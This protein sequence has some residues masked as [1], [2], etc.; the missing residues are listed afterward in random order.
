MRLRFVGTNG[1]E[2][3]DSMGCFGNFMSGVEHYRDFIGG[4]Y[5]RVDVSLSAIT[6]KGFSHKDVEK[7]IEDLKASSDLYKNVVPLVEK[8]YGRGDG[9]TELGF[10]INIPEDI[11]V[12]T[13]WSTLNNTRCAMSVFY[14]GKGVSYKTLRCLEA[15][16]GDLHTALVLMSSHS[17]VINPANAITPF[18]ASNI[19]IGYTCV[20]SR[21][22]PDQFILEYAKDPVAMSNF[23]PSMQE[24][25][26]MYPTRGMFGISEKFDGQHYNHLT[27]EE[28]LKSLEMVR[29]YIK[30]D[31]NFEFRLSKT[32]TLK[33]GSRLD[34]TSGMYDHFIH[35]TGNIMYGYLIPF[36]E[37]FPDA[38]KFS[39]GNVFSLNPKDHVL[40]LIEQITGNKVTIQDLSETYLRVSKEIEGKV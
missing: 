18:A 38:E 9:E 1:E 11:S 21:D 23:G 25:V 39:A 8:N 26:N 7:M 36:M 6:E 33:G 30:S 14:S 24:A 2:T 12:G 28:F 35:F 4:K 3:T 32:I 34:N 15:V 13:F 40:S 29:K 22:F 5:S 37:K 20:I 10:T 19:S 31:R 16:V 17:V 27:E